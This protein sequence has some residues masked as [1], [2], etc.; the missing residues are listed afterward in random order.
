MG[1]KTSL[2]VVFA[3]LVSQLCRMKTNQISLLVTGPVDSSLTFN[4]LTLMSCT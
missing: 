4:S 2:L 1:I 3:V